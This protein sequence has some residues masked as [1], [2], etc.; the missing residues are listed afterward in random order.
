MPTSKDKSHNDNDPKAGAFAGRELSE[1]ELEGIAGGGDKI[2]PNK[3]NPNDPK[4]KP[5]P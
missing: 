2:D 5:G 1:R 3:P 4:P